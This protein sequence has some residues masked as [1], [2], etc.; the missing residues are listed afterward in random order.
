MLL[1]LDTKRAPNPRKLRIYLAE[2]GLN[3]L[4]VKQLD[5]RAGEQR[6]PEFLR[7]NPFA[8][9]P[10]LELDDGTVIAESLAI[11]EYLEEIYPNPPLIGADP[12]TRALVRMWERRIEIGVYLPAS[13]MVLSKGEVSEHARKTLVARLALVNDGIQGREWVAGHFSI[14]DIMLLIGLDTAH[15]GGQFTLDPAWTNVSR[16]YERMKA[17]PSASV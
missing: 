10:I 11:M 12:V 7:K 1:Y 15:H 4:P 3:D 17:R 16:W 14:A 5:L 13:R 2:K 8:G 9:V 6:T